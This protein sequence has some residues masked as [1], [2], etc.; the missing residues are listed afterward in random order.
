MLYEVITALEIDPD[1]T[2]AHC[3]LG[4]VLYNDGRRD[5][6]RVCFERALQLRNNFV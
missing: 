1:F 4:A 2:D 5:E 3:N 6:A